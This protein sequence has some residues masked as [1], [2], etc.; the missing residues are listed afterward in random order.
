MPLYTL[1]KTTKMVRQK[2]KALSETVGRVN[3]THIKQFKPQIV[4]LQAP[5][6]SA[7]AASLRK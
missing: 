1:H 6:L 5:S 3:S 4:F 7:T 2:R